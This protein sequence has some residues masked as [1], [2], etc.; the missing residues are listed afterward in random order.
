V[1]KK[2]RRRSEFKAIGKICREEE[3]LYSED[4]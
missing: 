1:Y 4:E 3:G 2:K